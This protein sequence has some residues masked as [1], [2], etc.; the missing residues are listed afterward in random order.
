M[1]LLSVLFLLMSWCNLY[2]QVITPK[3]IGDVVWSPNTEPFVSGYVLKI[4]KDPAP[5]SP[6]LS[7]I[8]VPSLYQLDVG[9][10]TVATLPDLSEG[11]FHMHVYAYSKSNIF[12]PPSNRLTLDIKAVDLQYSSNGTQWQTD[13]SVFEIRSS[14]DLS[15]VPTDVVTNDIVPGDI[16]NVREVNQPVLYRYVYKTSSNSNQTTTDIV[17]SIES[18]GPYITW[19]IPHPE[20]NIKEFIVYRVD[21]GSYLKVG[22][23]KPPFISWKVTLSGNYCVK[24]V[25][26]N[27]ALSPNF[28]KEV[29][30]VINIPTKPT[31]LRLKQKNI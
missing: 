31:N 4:W 19:D 29:T 6:A 21:N 8:N 25:S 28:S 16:V 3:T 12:S 2:S 15:N 30:V 5:V 20:D 18:P 7:L 13:K 17:P 1:K 22:T 11:I 27:N 10:K 26:A 14:T 23:V 24:G 9:N